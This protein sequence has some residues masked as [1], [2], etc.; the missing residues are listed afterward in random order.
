MSIKFTFILVVLPCLCGVKIGYADYGFG[1]PEIDEKQIISPHFKIKGTLKS[2]DSIDTPK[3]FS[4]TSMVVDHHS[5]GSW[6]LP[7][8]H[9]THSI[10]WNRTTQNQ[11]S[12]R[13]YACNIRFHGSGLESTLEGFTSGGTGYLTLGFKNEYKKA[14]WHGFDKNETNRLHCYYSTNLNT[15]SNFQ[16]IFATSLVSL[17]FSQ[18]I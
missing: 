4:I 18:L 17:Q 11:Y 8:L 16:V 5:G 1:S 7:S 10:G 13:P 15:A 3:R 14:Y 9:D 6:Y 12:N 2:W